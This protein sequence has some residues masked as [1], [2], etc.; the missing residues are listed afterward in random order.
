[1]AVPWY[2]DIHDQI[3]FSE[4]KMRKVSLLDTP[5]CTLDLYCALPGQGQRPHVHTGED[6]AYYVL[7]GRGEILIGGETHLLEPGGAA[8]A[9]A[10][11]EHGLTNPGPD[12]LVVL[13]VIAPPI[14][15]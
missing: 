1:M 9:P 11:V 5:R 15:H 6:K 8:L 10:G 4:E 3:A 14:P 13:V 2:P 7:Q 12:N